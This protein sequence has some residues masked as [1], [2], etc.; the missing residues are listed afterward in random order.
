MKKDIDDWID[1][2]TQSENES[3]ILE[4]IESTKEYVEINKK[5]QRK[6]AEFINYDLEKNLPLAD[7]T[8]VF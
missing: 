6:I 8:N 7:I 2:S 1:S 4:K 3:D 5:L